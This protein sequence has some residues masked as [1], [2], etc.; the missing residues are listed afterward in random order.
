MKKKGILLSHI[1]CLKQYLLPKC[2]KVP[3]NY[4]KRLLLNLSYKKLKKNMTLCKNAVLKQSK[5]SKQNSMQWLSF[6]IATATYL[7]TYPKPVYNNYKLN[8]T[9]R[10]MYIPS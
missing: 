4:Y 10:L 6:K 7:A 2:C 5:T 8:I 3:K 1:L 9:S